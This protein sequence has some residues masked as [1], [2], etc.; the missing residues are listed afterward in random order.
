MIS[1]ND[2]AKVEMRVGTVVEATSV[3]GSDKLIK[4]QVHIGEDKPRQILTGMKA[5]FKPKYFLGKQIVIITNLEPR[6]MMGLASQGMV[7]AT[8]GSKGP[9]LLKPSKKVPNGSKIR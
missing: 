6:V 4:L 5:W 7:V 1:I 3:E 9:V 2:F 8:D